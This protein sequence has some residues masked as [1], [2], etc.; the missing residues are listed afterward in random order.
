MTIVKTYDVFCECED[1]GVR[2]SAWASGASS[3]E[4]AK[5]A[6]KNAQQQGWQRTKADSPDGKLRDLCP[7]CSRD[8]CSPNAALGTH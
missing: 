3:T 2:C 8:E 7:T 4:S 6:R 5:Q 1:L